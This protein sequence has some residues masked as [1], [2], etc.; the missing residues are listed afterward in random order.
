MPKTI[1]V[2]DDD[3]VVVISQ[4]RG[5][6]PAEDLERMKREGRADADATG[7]TYSVISK[8]YA[9]ER[10]IG[11]LS[12]LDMR[13]SVDAPLPQI[14]ARFAE[15]MP[16]T[17]FTTCSDRMQVSV[18]EYAHMLRRFPFVKVETPEDA[19]ELPQN[20]ESAPSDT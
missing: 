12:S 15:G 16:K 8:V 17:T 20:D 4:R 18:R 10:Q 3:L 7:Q 9:G 19:P 13:L 6:I 11:V 14:T 1:E 5:T 2:G